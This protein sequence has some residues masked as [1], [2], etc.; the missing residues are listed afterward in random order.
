MTDFANNAAAV[1]AGW[2]RVQTDRGATANPRYL[3]HYELIVVGTAG[4]SGCI[5]KADGEA[6]DAQ[7][8]ADTNALAAVNGQRKVR[9]GAGS[10][11]GKSGYTT[12]HTFDVT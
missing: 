11:A 9:Y 3:T 5:L 2:K 12:S 1:A 8:T 6:N 4:E 7:A 10:S